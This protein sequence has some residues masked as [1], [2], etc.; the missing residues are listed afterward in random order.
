[1][2]FTRTILPILKI[3]STTL[4]SILMPSLKTLSYGPTTKMV[5]ILQKVGALSFSPSQNLK[6]TTIFILVGRGFES[7]KFRKSTNF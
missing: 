3:T 2:L 7:W 4:T 6:P 5:F 1:M